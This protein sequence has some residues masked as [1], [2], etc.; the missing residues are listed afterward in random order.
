[1][2]YNVFGGTLNP[3]QCNVGGR[4]YLGVLHHRVDTNILPQD[5]QQHASHRPAQR[6]PGRRR[7]Q[8]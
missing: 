7:V 1:M 4:Q 2:T 8:R 6:H 5:T 3:T